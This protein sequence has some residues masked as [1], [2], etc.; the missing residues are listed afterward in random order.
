M[1]SLIVPVFS[2]LSLLAAAVNVFLGISSY[3]KQTKTGLYLACMCIIAAYTGVFYLVSA[4]ATD[5][6]IYSITSS[7]YFLGFDWMLI[8]LAEYVLAFTGTGSYKVSRIAFYIIVPLAV[9]DFLSIALNSL[10]GAAISYVASGHTF[11]SFLYV[12]HPLYYFHLAFTYSLI[13]FSF[14]LLIYKA[15][16]VPSEYKTQYLN[17]VFVI[18]LIVLIN[19]VFLFLPDT[20]LLA[21]LDWSVI[22]FSVATVL[23]YVC[24]FDY[25]KRDMM[26]NLSLTI[27]D[28]IDQGI[29]LFDYEGNFVMSNSTASRLL[30][31]SEALPQQ[32][33]NEFTRKYSIAFSGAEAE[34][35]FSIQCYFDHSNAARALRCDYR[36]LKGN[37][38]KTIGHQFVFTDAEAETDL[39]TGFHYYSD[40]VRFASSSP[41]SFAPP[42]AAA[43][44][45]I[46]N[47]K[48]YNS[49]NGQVEG[50][51][52][53]ST[54]SKIITGLLPGSYYIRGAEANLIAICYNR[55]EDEMRH[56]CDRIKERFNGQLQYAISLTSDSQP[57]V[58]HAIDQASEALQLKKYL[59]SNSR[60]SHVL[61]A[62]ISALQESDS[63][64]LDHVQRTQ[65]MGR[66]LGERLSLSDFEQNQLSLLCILHD[67]GKIGIPNEILNKPDKLTP[68]EYTLMK[69]HVEKGYQICLSSPE[70]SGIA[71]MVLRHHERWDGL[72]YPGGLSRE[73]IPL[74]SRM[75][76]VIDAY[77][78]MVHTRPYHRASDSTSAV[79]E[80]KRCAG[81][82]FDP[83]IVSEF[84]KLLDTL[85][86]S[87]KQELPEGVLPQE[88]AYVESSLMIDTSEFENSH[89]VTFTKYILDENDYLISVDPA[90]EKMSGYSMADIK[91]L[92][93]NQIDLVPEEDRTLY[94]ATVQSLFTKNK[95]LVY[96]EHRLLRKDGTTAY[97]FCSGRRYYSSVDGAIRN[98]IIAGDVSQ[99]NYVRL[100]R[101]E[102]DARSRTRLEKWQALYRTDP[103]TGLLSRIAFQ[104]DIQELLL[105]GSLR[106]LMLMVD[107]DN[108]KSYNDSYGHEAG[109][110]VLV[111]VS[112]I[113]KDAAG[114]GSLVCR[115]GGDEF[116]AAIT[117]PSNA[118]D[119]EIQS[120]ASQFFARVSSSLMSAAVSVT[121]S[122][123]ASVSSDKITDFTGL[124]NNSDAL[125]YSVK[126]SGKNA[127]EFSA[128][129]KSY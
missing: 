106:V 38:G 116:S 108:F 69:T 94:I 78:A 95:S 100:V 49:T 61:N 51:R 111:D 39:M 1:D 9:L 109:D 22:F 86:L 96:L 16:K 65:I 60:H 47:L 37:D 104:N 31:D 122:M 72:G 57:S 13:V 101:E 15:I 87:E 54:L 112:S 27:F 40:F 32:T 4:F 91:R 66:K 123:G 89:A 6:L 67:I 118:S 98:E 120:R 19:A 5:E 21:T 74:L 23:F 30:F 125:L 70:F 20:S 129:P 68:D 17:I 12:M 107:I 115:M 8:A 58:I 28:N 77:D 2:I 50:D 46:N 42:V 126:A 24:S 71:E 114:P 128:E 127:V 3:R 45:D 79:E 53:I 11:P 33:V 90:F 59:D 80:L 35:S 110:K 10:T 18:L 105:A 83:T 26:R 36:R 62:L 97:V 63:T 48:L 102:E 121:L 93:L 85:P 52:L 55:S 43:V 99:S 82:Q 73:T 117:F 34:D 41:E 44:F 81:S 29:V 25:V 56:L 7:L 64:T 92:H 14:V 88:K 76:S 84:I 113:L 75:I 103:L 119:S 124:Y